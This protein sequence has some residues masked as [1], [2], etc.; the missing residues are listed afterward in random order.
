MTWCATDLP[1]CGE[2]TE[3]GGNTEDE[4]IE[5]GKLRR[6][7]DGVVGLSRGV[8]LRKNLIGERLGDSVKEGEQERIW[9]RW[10]A[11]HW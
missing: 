10:F 8:H 7:D 2:V 6:R 9:N 4:G 5:L 3:T 1:L 11:T